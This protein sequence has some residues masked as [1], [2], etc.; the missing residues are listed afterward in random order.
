MRL[1]WISRAR[2]NQLQPAGDARLWYISA[3]RGWGKTLAGAQWLAARALWH[4]GARCAVVAPTYADARDT[5]VEGPSGL[6]TILP[7]GCVAQWN[8]SSGELY[9]FNGSRARLFSA[10]QPE[11]LRGPQHHYAWCDEFAAWNSGEAFDQLLFGLRLGDAPRAVIT[12]TPRA[13]PWVTSL[14]QRAARGLDVTLTHGTTYDNAANLPPDVLAQ[15][16]ERYAGT[17]LGRQELMAELLADDSES[18]WQRAQLDAL[19]V[20]AAPALVRTVVA[21]DPAM[22]HGPDSD[23]TGIVAAGL[24]ADGFFYVLA[25]ASRRARPEIW[26]DAALE[27]YRAL[28]ADLIVAE[29]NAGGALVEQLLRS[30][31]GGARFKA[32]HALRGKVERALPI[33]ALYERGCVRH[34]AALPALELQMTQ[35]RYGGEDS[36]GS[37]DRVDALVWALTELAAHN[38]AP[39]R[40]RMI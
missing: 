31:Q 30:R 38:A 5:C 4:D 2:P 19:R 25:D 20:D 32:V 14:M 26:A 8:R 34:A 7:P 33:A 9:F 35:M 21:I 6:L 23:E 28:N 37:P 29:V 39:P 40:V 18:M 3:G 17:R 36:G 16:T 12:T 10:D 1:A 11:R 27:L 24:G 13:R 15:L 22:S